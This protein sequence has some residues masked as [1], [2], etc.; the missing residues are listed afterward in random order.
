MRAGRQ[1][2]DRHALDSAVQGGEEQRNQG[3][4]GTERRRSHSAVT[5]WGLSTGT[6]QIDQLA[7]CTYFPPVCATTF[8]RAV[9]R[10][11]GGRGRNLVLDR[12]QW[13]KEIVGER[14]RDIDKRGREGGFGEG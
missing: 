6:A 10:R 5:H 4:S 11:E 9:S 14:A 12:P 2:L 1:A 8:V 7:S 3:S 13:W